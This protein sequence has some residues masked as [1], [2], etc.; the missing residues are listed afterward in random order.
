MVTQR[1][2]DVRVSDAAL[3]RETPLHYVA[4]DNQYDIDFLLTRA[5]NAGYVVFID[6]EEKP[7]GQVETF[8]YFGPSDD[9]H[10]ASRRHLRARMGNFADGLQ[11]DLSTANQVK[12]VEVRSWIRRTITNQSA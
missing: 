2:L 7:K 9:R 1:K 11:A 5:R 3:K 10:A 6:S 4:Q 8:L 12:C